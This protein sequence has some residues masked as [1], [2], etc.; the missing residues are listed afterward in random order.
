MTLVEAFACGV[1][2]IAPKLGSMLEIVTDGQT[3]LH[4][5][6]SDVQSLTEKI[7]WAWNHPEKMAEMGKQ[8]RDEYEK[9][10]TAQHNFRQL[11]DIYQKTII[12]HG[13]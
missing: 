1:P 2:V 12:N 3:G 9:K 6:T 10:Y 4:F 7:L 11:Q 5:E 8:A 13:K